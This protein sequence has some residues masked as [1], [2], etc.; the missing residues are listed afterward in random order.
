MSGTWRLRASA[1]NSPEQR[2]HNCWFRAVDAS[3]ATSDR[4]FPPPPVHPG[5]PAPGFFVHARYVRSCLHTVVVVALIS[6][7]L[8]SL[9]WAQETDLTPGAQPQTQQ[10]RYLREQR[11]QWFLRGRVVPGGHAASLRAQAHRQ[12]MQARAVRARAATSAMAVGS[13]FSGPPWRSIG[14]APL[15]SDASGTG[16][17]D[18]GWVSGRATSVAIDPADPTGNT[19]YIGGAYGGVWKSNKAGTL[20]LD[21]ANVTWAALTDN[22][23][24]LAVGA[25]A[26]QPGNSD[27]ARSVVLAGTGEANNSID[28]YYG[29][30]ILRSADAGNTWTLVRND[31]TGTRS[32]AG[33]GFSKIAF[34]SADPNT[35]VAAATATGK[36]IFL[37]LESPLETNRGLYYS[38]NAGASWNYANV[39]DGGVAVLPASATSVVY[40]EGAGKF[41]A[42]VQNHGFY[43]SSD[44]VNW[45]RVSGQLGAGLST[46]NCPANFPS[47]VC[48]LYRGEIAVVPKR[49]EMYVWYV[50]INDNDQGIW[51][52]VDG[53][54]SWTSISDAG[55]TNCGDLLGCGTEQG[56]YNLE[57]AAVPNGDVTDLYAGAINLYKCTITSLS[58]TCSGS[59]P[60]YFLNLT[61][62]YGCAPNL[63]SIA[64]VFPNQHGLDFKIAN[65]KAVM[66]FANDGGIYRTLDGYAGLTT[67]TC[68]G[69]NQF[70]SLNQTLGS[71]TQF[72]SFS[73]H[74]TDPNTLLGGTNNGSVATNSSQSTTSWLSVNSGTGGYSAINPANTTEWFTENSGISIQR[75]TNGIACR[76]QDFQN[77]EVVTGATLAGDTG[78]FYTPFILD[79]PPLAPPALQRELIVGT[80][81]VWRGPGIGGTFIPL[82]DS[83]ENRSGGCTGDEINMIRALAAGGTPDGSGLSNVIYVGTDGLGAVSGGAPGG[84]VWNTLSAID[85][86]AS[87]LDRTNNINPSAF[88]ISGIALDPSD[89][90]GYTAFV[91]IMG[92]GGTHVW[93]TVNAGVSWTDFTGSGNTQLPDAP[94][95]AVVVDPQTGV[96]YVATDVGVFSSPTA[97]P[98]WT[99]VGPSTSVGMLP[100]VA[101]TGLQIFNAYGIKKLRASTYGRGMWE[102]TLFTGPEFELGFKSA[103]QTTYAG[104][105]ATYDGTLMAYNGYANQVTLTC[106]QGNTMPPSIC[107]AVPIA[108]V[109]SSSGASFTLTAGGA[110]GDYSFV[111]QGKGNDANGTT[112]Q[113]PIALHIVDFSIGAPSPATITVPRGTTS[114][115]VTFQVTALGAFNGV[116]NLSCSGLPLGS[117]CSFSP[118]VTVMPVAGAPVSGSVRVL[119]PA[120]TAPGNSTVTI[121]GTVDGAPAT[122]TQTF[123]LQVVTNPDFVLNVTT[124]FPNV[125]A[126]SKKSGTINIASQDGFA[127]AVSLSCT[128]NGGGCTVS[129]ATVSSYPATSTVTVDATNLSAGT[130]YSTSVS[131]T[132]G[133]TT[134]VF[135][136][137]SVTDYQIALGTPTTSGQ[138]M[139]SVL[140]FSPLNT[141]T[142]M[143]SMTCDPSALTG[144]TCSLTPTGPISVGRDSPAV[145]ARI[146]L[147]SNPVPGTYPISVNTQDTDGAPKHTAVISVMVADYQIAVGTPTVSGQTVTSVLTFSP[148]NAYTGTISMTCDVS[149]LPGATWSLNPTGPITVGPG[150]RTVTATIGVPLNAPSGTYSILV[151]TQDTKGAAKHTA[152]VPVVVGVSVSDFTLN[153]T[154]NSQKIRAGL[155]AQYPLVVAPVGASYDDTVTFDP[156]SCSNSHAQ[157]SCSFS[158][159]SVVPGTSGQIAMITVNTAVA[160]ATGPQQRG[161]FVYAMCLP[162]LGIVLAGIGLRR[163]RVVAVLFCITLLALGLCIACGGGTGSGGTGTGGQPGTPAG[164]YQITVSGASGALV[165]TTQITLI[166]Q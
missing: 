157:I 64:H 101:V 72:V 152:V 21:P 25:I 148:L 160:I 94:A 116:V 162:G 130:N 142:G 151:N 75:C 102:T 117:I 46:A 68:G 126:G 1:F 61:H 134:H 107:A 111:V 143:V 110:V 76:E 34:S 10:E 92:F 149:A 58:P 77:E 30:G 35:V 159:A 81:R 91:T 67:G 147:P 128:L 95:D 14:P 156:Q 33:L 103:S 158:P 18:Y 13:A 99:E 89:S 15:A 3:R 17:Q 125:K 144:A 122:R 150:S 49:N 153:A 127:G 51:K 40:N 74:P 29:L 69:S 119:V 86:P 8:H 54:N 53:G 48:P 24:T 11:E 85:G 87:W 109:P 6:L 145:T 129:P 136:L 44:G 73:Q 20:A 133:N 118:A 38:K 146:T 96:V 121:T 84:H 39:A 132:S 16:L 7:G 79:P 131:G 50:D 98:V 97:M 140:T 100:N 28:T 124:P 12:K 135:S 57:I 139:T 155:S 41:Y 70:D 31:V 82:S 123:V 2:E 93:Q 166:V 62:A 55:I 45:S 56:Y 90:R 52:S 66:Y 138:V 59:G 105:S 163:Q 32:F 22:Q 161:M 83:F 115:D 23:E 120:G 88:P 4:S 36:G 104:H 114:A 113:F 9:V 165:H 43:S 108:V 37:G 137:P 63:G 47:T 42:A 27:P 71:L 5:A 26:I 60:N 19:V 106:L 141:Y 154:I 112:H 78:G 65:G 164:T 80:C